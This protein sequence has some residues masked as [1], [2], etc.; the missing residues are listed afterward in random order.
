M[1]RN[2][3]KDSVPIRQGASALD[4]VV[5]M[6]DIPRPWREQFFVALAGRPIVKQNLPFGPC[7]YAEDWLCWLEGKLA[8]EPTDLEER[9]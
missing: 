2:E 8:F 6:A 5:A 3:L 7:A 4:R 1:T 9:S